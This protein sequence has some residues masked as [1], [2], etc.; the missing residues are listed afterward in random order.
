[1]CDGGCKFC[2]FTNRFCVEKLLEKLPT[3]KI[4]PLLPES[5]SLEHALK[6]LKDSKYEDISDYED[7]SQVMT[8]LP[9][10]QHE[11]CS[12]LPCA[13]NPQY[14]DI[15][16]DESPKK[17]RLAQEY[18]KKQSLFE[19]E[20]HGHAQAQVETESLSEEKPILLDTAQLCTCPCFGETDDG[21]E[22]ICPKCDSERQPG[23]QTNHSFSC[24][25]SYEDF[26]DGDE[27]DDQMDD[28]IVLPI[29]ITSIIF[30]PENEIQ[31]IVQDDSKSGDKNGHGDMVPT[32]CPVPKP[33]AAS[34]SYNMEVFDTVKSFL[35]AKSAQF[36]NS[37]EIA[38]GGS[39]PEHEMV[40]E[41]DTHTP[42]RSTFHPEPEDS[43][44]TDDSCDYSAPLR[45]ETDK[46]TSEHN[47]ATN[48]QKR[49]KQA[50]R[51]E[52]LYGKAWQVD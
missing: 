16:E 1:M 4:C 38:S 30:E 17:K 42:K 15:S 22:H 35:Q 49:S 48:V 29:S 39:T 40:L 50:P 9:N 5:K 52:E 31:N 8:K 34:A 21:F 43:S 33:V 3:S 18:N 37:F 26:K 19:N 36:V 25:P 24:S 14:E 46:W 51:Q 32:D 23:V 13:E 7:V 6:L 44:E 11:K 47:K 45:P 27:G 41:G 12:F 28:F 10:T 20:G 2:A